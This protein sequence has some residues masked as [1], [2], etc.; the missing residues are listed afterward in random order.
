VQ[1]DASPLLLFL[2]AHAHISPAPAPASASSSPPISVPAHVLQR[3]AIS[4]ARSTVLSFVLGVGDRHLDNVLLTPHGDLLHVDFGYIFGQDPRPSM[5]FR[6]VVRVSPA[7]LAAL[8]PVEG[9]LYLT[10]L[11]EVREAY[12]ELRRRAS[13]LLSLPRCLDR[14]GCPITDLNVKQDC[15]TALLGIADRLQ[16]DRDDDD[17]RAYI[18]ETVL[19]ASNAFMPE[20]LEA[21]HKLAQRGRSLF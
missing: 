14:K 13:F 21:V 15:A 11:H 9:P 19:T 2:H 10:F 1:C 6:P 8:G 3:Y 12:V 18:Q 20:V 4:A 17:A 16:L 5:L 7:M